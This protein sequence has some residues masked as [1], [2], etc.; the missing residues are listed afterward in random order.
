MTNHDFGGVKRRDQCR[1]LSGRLSVGWHRFSI[2]PSWGRVTIFLYVIF[3]AKIII[4]LFI[5]EKRTTTT[6]VRSS[7]TRTTG[8]TRRPR[9]QRGQSFRY[10]L[11]DWSSPQDYVTK[12]VIDWSFSVK[13]D[14]LVEWLIYCTGLCSRDIDWLIFFNEDIGWLSDWVIDW[15]SDVAMILINWVIDL[16][17][18]YVAP[19]GGS[20]SSLAWLL[21]VR[22]NS[23]QDNHDMTMINDND[24]DSKRGTRTFK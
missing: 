16:L 9:R 1:M 4:S 8:R 14:W 7:T 13:N 23:A 10:W 24:D 6:T 22:S 21:G 20:D 3:V 5:R 18:D 17:Q 11:S 12:I 2:L 19:Q 15:M